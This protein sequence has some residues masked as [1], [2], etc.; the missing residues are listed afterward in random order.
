MPEGVLIKKLGIQFLETQAESFENFSNQTLSR[1]GLAKYQSVFTPILRYLYLSTSREQLVSKFFSV[2]Q[3]ISTK[4]EYSDFLNNLLETKTTIGIAQYFDERNIHNAK[5]GGFFIPD[6]RQVYIDPLI[7]N[8][9]KEG[10]IANILIH[11]AYHAGAFTAGVIQMDESITESITQEIMNE[12]GFVSNFNAYGSLVSE[13]KSIQEGNN[14][15][16]TWDELRELYASFDI[17]DD[18]EFVADKHEKFYDFLAML[19]SREI[20]ED[21]IA[22][23]DSEIYKLK[24]KHMI[25]RFLRLF[26]RLA[27]FINPDGRFIPQSDS[28]VALVRFDDIFEAKISKAIVK[29]IE[30]SEI[31]A[32]EIKTKLKSDIKEESIKKLESELSYDPQSFEGRQL[33]KESIKMSLMMKYSN[34]PENFPLNISD[35]VDEFFREYNWQNIYN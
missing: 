13:L 8:F 2:I 9:E 17:I 21:G 20:Y 35:I 34:L 6:L 11:E 30:S 1:F 31:L 24:L 10:T 29:R 12:L 7:F 4:R 27:K 19:A 26:P 23:F 16:F 5:V 3:K 25:Q 33:F 15:Y 18:N 14:E 22:L 28:E 32:L